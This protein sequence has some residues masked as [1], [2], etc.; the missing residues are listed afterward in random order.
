MILE[1]NVG[2]IN[3]VNFFEEV[4]FLYTNCIQT[5]KCPRPHF[6]SHWL[7][8]VFP[9]VSECTRAST[10]SIW[11]ALHFYVFGSFP[12]RCIIKSCGW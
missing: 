9:V 2:Y 10:F 6:V 8:Y 7:Q 11:R 12:L 3:T 4:H 1:L 5:Q